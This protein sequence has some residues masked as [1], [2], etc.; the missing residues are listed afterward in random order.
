MVASII[1][2]LGVAGFIYFAFRAGDAW[3]GMIAIYMGANCW[4]GFKQAQALSALAKLPRRHGYSCPTCQSSPPIGEYWK[5]HNCGGAFDTFATGA[6]CPHCSTRF[7]VTRCVDCGRQHPMS[8]WMGQIVM[9]PHE[10]LAPP[11]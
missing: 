5:C 4:S 9:A 8:E 10:S 2:F 11:L 1:G 3:L 7:D 6:V